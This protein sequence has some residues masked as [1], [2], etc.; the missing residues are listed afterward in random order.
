MFGRKGQRIEHW[1]LDK[2][3]AYPKNPRKHP[4]AQVAAIAG[5][6]V[7]FGFNCPILVDS[8]GGIIA[9]HGRYLAGL[10]LGLDTVP[11]VVLDHLSETEKRA[12]ILADNKLAE[13]SSFDD[14]I[15]RSELAELREA[16][17]DLSVLGFD[18]EELRVLLA[19]ADH[20]L[21]RPSSIT[22]RKPSRSKTSRLGCRRWSAR[23]NK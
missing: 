3:T 1:R 20:G 10:K 4:D 8:K 23:P 16:E 13:L 15:L 12:Y 21:L 19:E 5:S 22:R 2:L 6:I 11:V 9:G 18:D 7:A 17:I 14:D